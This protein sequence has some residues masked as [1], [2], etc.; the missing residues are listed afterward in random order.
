MR[1]TLGAL[2]HWTAEPMPFAR[3]LKITAIAGLACAA[4]VPAV[5][6]ANRHTEG[7]GTRCG[8]TLWRLMTLSDPDRMKVN[9]HGEDTTIADIARLHGPTRIGARRTTEFQRQVW[10]MR[11]VIDRYRIASNGEI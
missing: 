2:R 10:R 9:L 11:A 5:A 8:G 4:L 3:F 7:P 1:A 6:V